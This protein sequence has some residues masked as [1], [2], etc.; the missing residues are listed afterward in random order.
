[1]GAADGLAVEAPLRDFDPHNFE[2]LIAGPIDS[3]YSRGV[4]KVE[5]SVPQD[6]PM[7]PPK[8]RFLTEI[9]HPNISETG[10]ICLDTLKSQWSP[11]LT[12]ENTLLSVI[13]LLT[14]PNPD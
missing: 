8:L 4:W 14:D 10:R 2:A 5:V 7:S 3:A 13:S 11:A 1:M 9:W 6:Y 12:L